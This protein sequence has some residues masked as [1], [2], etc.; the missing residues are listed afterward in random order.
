MAITWGAWNSTTRLRTGIEIIQS[1]S[2]VDA[3]TASVTY[4]IR[5]YLQ[6]Y[7]ASNETGLSTNWWISGAS[8]ASGN[9]DWNLGAMGTKLMGTDTLVVTLAYGA[10]QTKTW[11]AQTKSFYFVTSVSKSVTVPDRPYSVRTKAVDH[12]GLDF[13][14]RINAMRFADGGFVSR[15]APV[16]S[17]ATSLVGMAIEGTI[18]MGNGLWG[19]MRAVVRDEMTS[20][21]RDARVLVGGGR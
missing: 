13:M 9:T 2:T 1:P 6:T 5:N 20:V 15:S 8:A 4:T 10:T 21:A 3:N 14:H 16:A 18:D 19:H 12:Y 11:T 17:P 7:Y